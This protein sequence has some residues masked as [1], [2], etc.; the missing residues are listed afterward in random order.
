M[1]NFL[2]QL[3]FCLVAMLLAPLSYAEICPPKTPPKTVHTLSLSNSEIQSDFN[4]HRLT[5]KFKKDDVIE[6]TNL[7]DAT[8]LIDTPDRKSSGYQISC[9]LSE[10]A[11]DLETATNPV[12]HFTNKANQIQGK[13]DSSFSGITIT[14]TKK[15][16]GF[17]QPILM[18]KGCLSFTV[19][20]APT[21]AVTLTC[22]RTSL[23]K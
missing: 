13:D 4:E 8:V 7:G 15:T 21:E 3:S 17:S 6:L 5:A 19:D 14:T 22:A 18:E 1:K 12:L 16:F 23:I 10:G 11:A 20:Q 2:Q 9:V